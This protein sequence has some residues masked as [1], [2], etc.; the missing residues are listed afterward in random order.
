ML[1][2]FVNFGNHG[3]QTHVRRIIDNNFAG[4]GAGASNS[5]RKEFHPSHQRVE[6]ELCG[7]EHKPKSPGI[8][9]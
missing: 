7:R 1:D 3:L 2:T 4:A 5:R 8:P 6:V 9:I